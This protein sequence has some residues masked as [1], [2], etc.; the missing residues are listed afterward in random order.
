LR[1]SDV[2][3]GEDFIT[4]DRNVFLR[5]SASLMYRGFL[6]GFIIFLSIASTASTALIQN[7][8]AA[9]LN[10]D[11]ATNSVSLNYSLTLVENLTLICCAPPQFRIALTGSN[12]SSLKESLT[13][14]VQRLVPTA[15]VDQVTLEASGTNSSAGTWTL[16][17]N[18]MIDVVGAG[19]DS[20]G[21]SSVNLAIL[22]LDMSD[23][24]TI[25]GVELNQVGSKY[26][27]PPLISFASELGSTEQARYYDNGATFLNSV[28]P[29]NDATAFHLLDFS[30]FPSLKTWTHQYNP[31]DQSSVWTYVPPQ[32]H[33]NLT[34]GR[35]SPEQTLFSAY[36]ASYSPS[37]EIIG[38]ARAWVQGQTVL[39]DMGSSLEVLMTL[40]GM[41]SLS[42][43]IVAF[44]L[45]RSVSRQA[46]FR[47]KKR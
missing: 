20:G 5:N 27:V 6:A 45:D 15:R 22:E 26:L 35:L 42:V 29:E 36:A 9:S 14:A 17:E 44:A 7:A 23:P 11:V 31:L 37:L 8:R 25:S 39:F 4:E 2:S 3:P 33:Y 47:K 21:S 28:V 18:Y 43:G 16:Q 24:L 30:W 38:P 12:G 40:I 41:A 10:I 34:F 46:R 1:E 13:E 32:S 19:S